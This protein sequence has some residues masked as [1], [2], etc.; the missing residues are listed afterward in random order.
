MN[1]KLRKIELKDKQE[2]LEMLKEYEKSDLFPGIDRYEGIRNFEKLNHID[3]ELWLEEQIA[4]E[5]DENLP[6][7]FSPQTVFIAVNEKDN[8]VG[9]TTLRWKEVPAL[10]KFGG[11][12]GYSIRPSQRGN[13]Y[14][15]QV[16]NLALEKM[17]E[18]GR[19]RVLVCCKDFNL[20]S[21]NTIESCGGKYDSTYYN[22][23]DGCNHL[24]YW[25]YKDKLLEE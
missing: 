25:I 18:Q 8:I 23:Q 11:Y 12:V 17:W 21:K 5:E 16:L 22:A 7:D 9:M 1:L 3:F 6:D 19:N 20:P 4:N 15:K 10:V 13:G 14:A 2:L 24:R